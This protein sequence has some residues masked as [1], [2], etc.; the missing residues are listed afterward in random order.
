LELHGEGDVPLSCLEVD[1]VGP[2]FGWDRAGHAEPD[3]SGLGDQDLPPVTVEALDVPGPDGDDAEALMNTLAP[4][5][6]SAVRASEEVPP[7]LVEVSEGLLLD[8]DR[9]LGHPRHRLPEFGQ[10][11]SLL[12]VAGSRLEPRL[13]VVP[14]LKSQVPDVPGI[15]AMAGKGLGLGGCRIKTKSH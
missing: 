12:N 9:P 11:P 14:L 2:G 10:L 7:G 6:G 4:P 8:R 3:P 1:P 15:G 5:R 13:P